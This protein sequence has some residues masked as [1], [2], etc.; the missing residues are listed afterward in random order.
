MVDIQNATLAGGVAIG[1]V[2]DMLV[3]PVGAILIGA[4]GG[5]ISVVGYNKITPFLEDKATLHDTCGIHNLHGL[6]SIIS[7]M[8]ACIV[9]A[10]AKDSTYGADLSAV[11]IKRPDRSALVQSQMQVAFLFITLAISMS[12]GMAT[13]WIAKHQLF[14]PM[15]DGHLFLDVESWEVPHLETPFYFDQRGEVGRRAMQ[16]SDSEATSH[17]QKQLDAMGGVRKPAG[18]VKDDAFSEIV[19]RLDIIM[20]ELA[21]SR[22]EKAKTR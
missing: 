15:H 2:A 5:F 9:A 17:A 13:G 14:D 16:A 1:A 19:D 12:A 10:L 18:A 20:S 8:S 4:V 6:P 22:M 7:G 3:Y 21:R 11:Y